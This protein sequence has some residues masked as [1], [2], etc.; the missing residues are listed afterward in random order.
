MTTRDLM[1]IIYN[2][3][4]EYGIR[5]LSDIEIKLKEL[6]HVPYNFLIEDSTTN[7]LNYIN[8]SISIYVQC[9]NDKQYGFSFKIS[10]GFIHNGAYYYMLVESFKRYLKNQIS[11]IDKGEVD[12]N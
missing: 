8:N 7:N 5:R 1:F 9:P 11:L 3:I 4:E 12:G 6:I 2:I 10:N